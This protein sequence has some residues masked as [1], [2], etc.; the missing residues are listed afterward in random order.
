[1]TTPW[2][3]GPSGE[4][5]PWI[6]TNY[7]KPGTAHYADSCLF[8]PAA[9]LFGSDNR[10]VVLVLPKNSNSAPPPVYL[11]KG[12]AAELCVGQRSSHQSPPPPFFVAVSSPCDFAVGGK[13]G[14]LQSSAT[15]YLKLVTAVGRRRG[16]PLGL[17]EGEAKVPSML[18][19]RWRAPG[20][21]LIIPFANLRQG[22]CCERGKC[23]GPRKQP[24]A[25]WRH[26]VKT[27]S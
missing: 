24:S 21:S 6:G 7:L 11:L 10:T 19:M 20:N 23:K 12:V 14:R 2:R 13:L 22:D 3:K 26:L 4:G 9:A 16:C 8:H 17:R 5:T 1:M 25:G 15:E 27:T 18:C